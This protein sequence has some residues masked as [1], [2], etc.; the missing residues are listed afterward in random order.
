MELQESV[1]KGDEA[2]GKGMEYGTKVHEAAHLLAS[3]KRPKEIFDEIPEIERILD[4]VKTGDILTEIECTLPVGN[5]MI[6]GIIDMLAV[7]PDRVEIHDYKTD[8]DKSF[9]PK[10]EMQ[11]SVYALSAGSYFNLPVKCFVD[12]LSLKESIEVTPFTPDEVADKV[13]TL[14]H[15]L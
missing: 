10:Y 5:V 7:F 11:L 2:G 6:R 1:G 15:D 14:V 12:F 8:A 9:L 3:G 4:S 13:K